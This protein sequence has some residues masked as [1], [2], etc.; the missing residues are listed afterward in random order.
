MKPKLE[1]VAK[2]CGVS[3]ATVSRVLNNHAVK[4]ETRKRVEQAIEEL[5]YRPNLA[6]RSLIQHAS[7]TIGIVVSSLVNPYHTLLLDAIEKTLR[8]AG[9]LSIISCSEDD[10]SIEV[11]IVNSLLASQVDGIIVAEA[12]PLNNNNGF[13]SDLGR[14]LPLVLIN[15]NPNHV[16]SSLVM[17]DQESGMHTVMARLLELGHERI[18]FVMG[19]DSY[20][21]NVK[22]QVYKRSLEAQGIAVSEEL[23]VLI[24]NPNHYSAIDRCAQGITTLLKDPDTRPTAVFAS[25][26]F[27]GIG[28]VKAI[29]SAGL[30]MPEDVSVVAQDNTYLSQT[31]YPDLSTIDMNMALLGRSAIDMLKQQIDTKDHTPRKLVFFP[32][33]IERGSV[34]ERS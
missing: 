34:G 26:E 6:A 16:S 17:M 9:Y 18:A 22:E 30:R 24:S 33:F 31:L 3:L 13:F 25:N 27:L 8:Q 29:E 10:P 19:S 14:Q 32:T 28:A 7:M 4:P 11:D 15:G 2:A 1:D 21:F 12:T 20:S 5:N 23:T